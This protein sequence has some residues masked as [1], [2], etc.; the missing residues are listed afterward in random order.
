M[1]LKPPHHPKLQHPGVKRLELPSVHMRNRR[2]ACRGNEETPVSASLLQT[3]VVGAEGARV[4]RF[5]SAY[6][7]CL[8]DML[9]LEKEKLKLN[10]DIPT[11]VTLALGAMSEIQKLK[12]ACE[13]NFK[14]MDLTLFD[15]LEA[16][17]L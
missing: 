7:G 3:D 13:A 17:A 5:K 1:P 14:L 8:A 6:D 9:A 4:P 11:I 15:T 10:L 16:R 12:P 2:R